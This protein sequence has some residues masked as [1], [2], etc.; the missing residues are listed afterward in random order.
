MEILN[1]AVAIVKRNEEEVRKTAA[2]FNVFKILK[3]ESKEVQT[4]SNFICELLDPKGSHCLGQMPLE[5]FVDELHKAINRK[6][7]KKEAEPFISDLSKVKVKSEYY[8]GPKTKTEGGYLDILLTDNSNRK[9]IIEN[10]IYAEDQANQL[11]RYSNYDKK[12]K[13]FYLTLDGKKPSEISAKGLEE[14]EDFFCLSYRDNMIHWLEACVLEAE[15]FPRVKE[16]IRQYISTLQSLTNQ[17][18]NQA[19]SAKIVNE[20]VSS[21]DNLKAFFSLVNETEKVKMEIRKNLFGTISAVAKEKG[22]HV[23]SLDTDSLRLINEN[24][25][26]ANLS[27]GFEFDPDNEYYLSYGFEII[28]VEKNISFANDLYEEFENRLE[29]HKHKTETW[30]GYT[31]D[32]NLQIGS[33]ESYIHIHHE[34][35]SDSLKR[36][37]AEILKKMIEVFSEATK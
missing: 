17:S 28:D 35:E 4:H 34:S 6:R 37:Y 25:R 26:K 8:I 18:K 11:V 2:D 36:Q 1:R 12:A 5:L 3:V 14:N 31:W 21:G 9:V 30:P 22:L 32:T 23:D 20:V 29:G 24:L 10:K 16:T 19:M 33:N 15:K 27:I 13:L 7:K